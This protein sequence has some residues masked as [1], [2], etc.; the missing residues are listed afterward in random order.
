MVRQDFPSSED[1]EGVGLFDGNGIFG[2]EQELMLIKQN[3]E[4]AQISLVKIF[5]QADHDKKTN[6][7]YR[8]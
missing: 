8:H 2:Y 4:S 5:K 3:L 1:F 6:K 7:Y